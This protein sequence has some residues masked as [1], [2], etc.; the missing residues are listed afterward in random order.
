MSFIILNLKKLLKKNKYILFVVLKIIEFLRIIFGLN[1]RRSLI[2]KINKKLILNNEIK[3]IKKSKFKKVNIIYDCNASPL[4]LGDFFNV[5]MAARYFQMKGYFIYFYLIKYDLNKLYLKKNYSRFKI[6]YLEFEKILFSLLKKKF[7]YKKENWVEFKKRSMDKSLILFKKRVLNRKYTY[8]F[9]FNLLNKLC[10][11]ESHLFLN[12]YLLSRKTL[13][14]SNKSILPK[15]KYI[16]IHCR[17]NIRQITKKD[18]RNLKSKEYIKIVSLLKKKFK[19]YNLIIVSDKIGCKYFKKISVKNN[20]KVKFSK[21]FTNS[22]MDDGV[23]VLNSKYYFQL[24]SG[25]ICVFTYYSKIPYLRCTTS[26]H[27]EIPYKRNQLAVWHGKKNFIIENDKR[28]FKEFLHKI[29][30]IK[31]NE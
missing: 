7:F 28:N 26:L 11:N 17:H 1:S 13:K 5:A 24:W 3:I 21:N 19:N 18:N 22:F 27:N 2:H 10:L 12:K 4:T 20:L 29:K 16:T 23:L 8:G 14:F 6:F 30:E 15:D 31:I 25:G 9:Y